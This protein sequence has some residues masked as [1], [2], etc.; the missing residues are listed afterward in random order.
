MLFG[1]SHFS[2]SKVRDKYIRSRD[3]YIRSSFGT[4]SLKTGKWDS[5]SA[6]VLK[7]HLTFDVTSDN[8]RLIKA[9]ITK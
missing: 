6:S 8:Q 2:H 5:Y 9:G 7:W 1:Y 3:K 4:M